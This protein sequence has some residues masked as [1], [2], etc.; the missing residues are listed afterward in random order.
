MFVSFR[1][2]DGARQRAHRLPLVALAFALAGSLPGVAAAGKQ[3][4]TGVSAISPSLF[5]SRTAPFNFGASAARTDAVTA[6]ARDYSRFHFDEQAHERIEAAVTRVEKRNEI[7]PAKVAA[8]LKQAKRG[9]A[10]S[11]AGDFRKPAK[12][13]DP[14]SARIARAVAPA[15]E[16][17]VVMAFASPLPT[18]ENKPL[19]AIAS[20][21]PIDG[22]TDGLAA[23]PDAV[24]IP[25]ARPEARAKVVQEDEPDKAG[26]RIV[27]EEFAVKPEKTR[28]GNR[29]VALAKPENPAQGNSDRPNGSFGQSLRNIFGGGARAGNGVAVYDISA[30]KV[31]MPDGSVLEAASGIGKMANNPRYANVKMNGPT[32]PHTYNL[33][34]RES[35]FHGV[36]AIRML[37]VDGKNKF[38][39]AGILA[40]TQLLRG[41]PGQSHGC[42]AFKDYN[43]FLRAFKQGKVK[44]MIVVPSGGSAVARRGGKAKDV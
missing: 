32:P 30:R 4:F 6:Y 36:E 5:D 40:H 9:S 14:A 27:R 3:A 37:P 1:L 35:R 12:Q 19:A 43:K 20:V 16:K 24:E 34:M 18:E 38:G 15:G 21:A 8:L 25:E 13:V 7:D 41:R 10:F 2:F 17:P 29:E 23:L 42:V 44:Q 39:R 11:M 26:E 22:E 33:R 31:Y 28:P